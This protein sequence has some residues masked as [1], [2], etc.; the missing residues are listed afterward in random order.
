STAGDA[1]RKGN[2][3]RSAPPE[4]R[5]QFR[6][7]RTPNSSPNTIGVTPAQGRAVANIEWNTRAG[8]FGMQL[9]PRFALTWLLFTVSNS[10]KRWR[11]RRAL[12]SSPRVQQS[13]SN[14]DRSFCSSRGC[15]RIAVIY[16]SP[17]IVSA[18]MEEFPR[19]GNNR[20]QSAYRSEVSP[21]QSASRC[22]C[23]GS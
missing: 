19:G 7:V 12:H 5:N 8:K 21:A 1:G 11:A 13:R 10:L 15:L 23:L 17:A 4:S 16:F 18:Q 6:Q 2:R 3:S 14:A 9:H 22:F 20:F